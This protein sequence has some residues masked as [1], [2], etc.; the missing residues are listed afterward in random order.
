[1]LTVARPAFDAKETYLTCIRSI[2]NAALKDRLHAV[3]AHVEN[4]AAAY[5]SRAEVG[6]LHL[7]PTSNGIAGL[8]SKQEM[9]DVYKHRMSRLGSAG[10]AVYDALRGLPHRGTCPFCAHRKV[11]TLDHVLP[12]S[13]FSALA[14]AP[15][16][17]VA[18]C[19]D[20][21]HA[22]STDAPTGA[23]DVPLHPYFDDVSGERWLGAQVVPGSIAAVTF[24]VVPVD[25]WTEQLNQRVARHFC[26][27]DLGALYSSQAACEISGQRTNVARIYK[28][29][30]S[31]GVREELRYQ[32]QSRE[33]V[34]LNT[35]QA[36]TYRA[37]SESDWYCSGGFSGQ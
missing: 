21:N 28:A 34:G 13:L 20:C 30:G 27:F 4:A 16:N 10:Q 14:V 3:A 18:A 35:W 37:L 31:S 5:A 9:V 23:G 15:D 36:A 33:H 32:K 17:L 2:R 26:G 1:M 12:K 24:H 22:K 25:G 11:S 19:K 29:R 7:V 8:V 6:Q